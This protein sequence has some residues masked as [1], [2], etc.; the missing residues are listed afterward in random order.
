MTEGLESALYN[1]HVDPG[2]IGWMRRCSGEMCPQ[3]G[4]IRRWRLASPRH[5]PLVLAFVVALSGPAGTLAQNDA[6]SRIRV[7]TEMVVVPVTVKDNHGSL[8]LG[9]QRDEFRIF[10]DDVEQQIAL[11]SADP[12]PLSVVVLIDNGLPTKSAAR[13]ERSAVALAASFSDADEVALVLF[14][15]YPETVFE[16][17]ADKDRI[18]TQFKRLHLA[19][20]FPGQGSAAMTTGP[21]VNATPVGPGVPVAPSRVARPSKNIEDAIYAAARLLRNRPRDRR[22]IVFVISD[23]NDSGK[24]TI[25]FEDTLRQLLSADIAVY[26]IDV[27]PAL[28]NRETNVLGHYARRTGGD[29]FHASK[30]AELERLYPSVTEQARNQY[31]LGYLPRNTDRARDYHSIEVRVRRS[32]LTLLARD[33]YFS[34]TQK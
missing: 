3:P 22:K 15:Q 23:G 29:L 25:G 31:T 8:V 30:Q 18:F 33:G 9:L 10:E 5:V 19:S 4:R 2:R 21:R 26:A 20:R 14:E 28:L 16:L 24:N 17:T 7:T 12:V 34:P 1:S 11:F 32:D 6:R 13:V 27:G